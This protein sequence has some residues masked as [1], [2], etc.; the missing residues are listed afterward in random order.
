MKNEKINLL[1]EINN[2][3]DMGIKSNKILDI[4]SPIEELIIEHAIMKKHY[5]ELVIQNQL[6]TIGEITGSILET[7]DGNFDKSKK[8]PINWGPDTWNILS[9]N[10]NDYNCDSQFWNIL[11]EQLM[12][13]GKSN[14]DKIIED[15]LTNNKK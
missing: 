2:F 13:K 1:L 3:N 15:E 9:K 11:R 14:I 12:L 8:N 4:N 10:F 5:E 7:I 6:K